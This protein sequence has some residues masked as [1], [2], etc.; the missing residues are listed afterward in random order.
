MLSLINLNE[1]DSVYSIMEASFPKDERRPYNEQLELMNNKH[2]R[3]YVNKKASGEINAF[4]AIWEFDSFI[5]AEHFAVSE[6]ARNLGL[7]SS[8]LAEIRTLYDKLLCLEVELPETSLTKRRVAFYERN[9]FFLN[10][11]PYSQPP[12]SKGRNPV[13]LMIMISG[14][15]ITESEFAAIRDVLYKCVYKTEVV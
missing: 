1:F 6:N 13:P 3:L 14:R 5:F 4:I 10:L 12:I 7:G 15:S 2:Y 8:I 11:Y 9:G